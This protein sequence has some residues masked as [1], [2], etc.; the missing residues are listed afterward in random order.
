MI[1]DWIIFYYF[2]ELM[3]VGLAWKSVAKSNENLVIQKYAT[4]FLSWIPFNNQGYIWLSIVHFFYLCVRAN[5][6]LAKSPNCDLSKVLLHIFNSICLGLLLV[7][8]IQILKISFHSTCQLSGCCASN[9]R[10]MQRKIYF[11][12]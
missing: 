1:F 5:I 6:H 9:I 8:K 7:R 2:L 11:K 4:L 12:I 3:S 10:I